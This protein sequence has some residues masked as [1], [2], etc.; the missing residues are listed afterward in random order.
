[1]ESFKNLRDLLRYIE[2]NYDNPKAL[3]YRVNGIWQQFST[4]AF[5]REI[6][7]LALGL[8]SL[9]LQKGE[10]VGLMA[11][12]SP[13]WSI[14]DLAIM[15]AGGVSV[16]IF[17]NI[18]DDNFLVEVT[19]TKLKTILVTSFNQC[20]LLIQHQNLFKTMIALDEPGQDANHLGWQQVIDLGKKMAELE[21]DCFDRLLNDI[22]DDDLATIIYTSGSTGKPKGVE[23]LQKNLF[24]I[25]NS[26]SFYW[27]NK[28]D[29]YLSVLPLA[30]VFG[31]ALN[32]FMIGWGV[33]IYYWNDPKSLGEIC[34]E[35]RPTTMVVVP[36]LLE[37]VYS[38]MLVQIYKSSFIKRKIALWAFNLAHT[39][40]DSLYKSIF[41]PLAD[42]LVYSSLREAL[43]GCL[44]VVISGGA[45]LDPS[46]CHFLIEIGIPIYEGWGL[47][48]AATVAINRP[49]NV[50]IGTVGTPLGDMKIK[51]SPEGEI[52][53]KGSIVMHQYFLQPEETA[54]VL[55]SEGWLH[56]GDNGKIDSDGHLTIVGRI[57]DLYKTSTGEYIAPVP[58]EQALC[59]NPMIEMAM[60]VGEG[61]K[62]ASCL[63]FP[64]FEVV[65]NLKAAQKQSHL[66]TEEFLKGEFIKKGMDK[67]IEKINR[68]LNHWEQIHAYRFIL[69]PPT[70]KAGELTPSLKIR[71]N[72][73]SEKYKHI[74][75]SM[76]PEDKV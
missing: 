24:S 49:G 43:G 62:F 21:P 11:L 7:W 66:A 64:N 15:A 10:K 6:K 20:Q 56:T 1:M 68:H 14:A 47:T 4:Q 54:K 74:I 37:K 51:I 25:I 36:R 44:R 53:V 63:L 70:V 75:D 30:H 38:Q 18:S 57:K 58:I 60:V 45:H 69:E 19:E 67:T 76:Y 39:Q 50:K 34:R 31:R 46:L 3:N 59:K 26:E 8:V 5:L 28:T 61:R 12:P 42:K 23:S 35:V 2:K 17:S 32:F 52:L 29:C 41:K 16:P 72:V 27:D 40:K 33:S 13:K 65:E 48:E 9:G 73:I 71:R 22:Q 55:D